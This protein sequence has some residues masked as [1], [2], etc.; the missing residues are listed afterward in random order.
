MEALLGLDKTSPLAGD[1]DLALTAIL[2]VLENRLDHVVEE[3]L[4]FLGHCL[5]QFDGLDFVLN[6][7]ATSIILV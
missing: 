4:L 7:A 3:D 6:N 2:L 1:C 5:D